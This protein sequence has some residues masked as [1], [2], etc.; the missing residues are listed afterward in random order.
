MRLFE[1]VASLV[2]ADAHGML[3]QLEER[4]L[5]LK[6]HL[7][8]AEIEIDHKRARLGA[9]ADEERRLMEEAEAL[10]T[11]VARLDDDVELALAGSHEELARFAVRRLL[12]GQRELGERRARMSELA[13]E[14]QRLA[15]Q[16]TG[17]EERFQALRVQVRA[18][19]ARTTPA[20][21]WDGAPEPTDVAEEEVDLELLRRRERR[22]AQ[23]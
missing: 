23:G 1:R 12:P 16:L 13:E 6:Q 15:E 4:G 3:D 19:L 2:K 8:E 10:A 11:R 17:Q 22:E 5:L 7:R 21:C 20:P 18:R 9:L 14:R